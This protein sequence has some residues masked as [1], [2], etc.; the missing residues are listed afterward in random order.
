MIRMTYRE[1]EAR[2]EHAKNG[3]PLWRCPVWCVWA[4]CPENHLPNK[5]NPDA[6][7]FNWQ[8]KSD[9]P[10]L[11]TIHLA[12]GFS[13]ETLVERWEDIKAIALREYDICNREIA[14]MDIR[15]P[16]GLIRT[17]TPQQIT[18]LAEHDLAT[19]NA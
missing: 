11:R 8:R 6:V 17:F 4:C 2:A 10:Q 3:Y 15:C 14:H 16:D 12:N 9:H 7:R 19:A 18:S 13:Y 1:E 5:M